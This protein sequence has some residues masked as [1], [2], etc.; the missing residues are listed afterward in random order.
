MSFF[1]LFFFELIQLLVEETTDIAINIWT[2]LMKDTPLSLMRLVFICYC[3]GGTQ[4]LKDWS[5]LRNA[6]VGFV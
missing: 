1:M 5:S 2:R 3:A 4:S 6:F